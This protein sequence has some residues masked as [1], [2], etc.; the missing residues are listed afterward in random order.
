ME[1][2]LKRKQ[3]PNNLEGE[4]HPALPPKKKQRER[5]YDE[6]YV[7]LGF[8]QC[9]L[10]VTKPQCLLCFK[11]L[12]NDAMKSS[13]KIRRL[14]SK[15]PEF[16]NKPQSFFERKRKEYFKQKEGFTKSL[17]SNEKLLKAS[18][19]VALRVA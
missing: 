9:S 19:L 7:K 18:Y 12:S 3:S 5:T 2:F 14:M 4:K 11:A 8:I 10:D 17:L 16:A 13:K 1:K 6:E 15:H